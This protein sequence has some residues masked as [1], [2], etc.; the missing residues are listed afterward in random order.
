MIGAPGPLDDDT[1]LDVANMLAVTLPAK[2]V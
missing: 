1:V 2:A